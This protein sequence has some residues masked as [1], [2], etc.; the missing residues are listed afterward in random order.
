MWYALYVNGVRLLISHSA[1]IIAQEIQFQVALGKRC[2]VR[3]LKTHE[4]ASAR[5]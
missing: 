4:A 1:E 5:G 3:F 2:F